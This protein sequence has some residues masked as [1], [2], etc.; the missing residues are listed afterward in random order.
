MIVDRP[1]T[2]VLRLTRFPCPDEFGRMQSLDALLLEFDYDGAIVPFDDDRQ[3]VRT[4]EPGGPIFVR[5]DRTAEAAARTPS[6]RTAWCRCG[7]PPAR[8]QKAGW[9]LSSAAAMPPKPG[10]ALSPNELPALQALGWRNQIDGISALAWSNP[11]AS[12]T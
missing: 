2:P 9:C 5:R 1:L 12:A 11:S 10:R 7:W 3:F 4:D 8:R 6:A